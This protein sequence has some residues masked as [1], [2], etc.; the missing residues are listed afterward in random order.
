MAT[1]C[2]GIS[3]FTIRPRMTELVAL[4]LARCVGRRKNGGSEGIYQAIPLE[5]ARRKIEMPPEGDQVQ[6][7]L[8]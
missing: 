4:G 2:M 5:E 3:L 1:D 8:F 6:Q 7:V